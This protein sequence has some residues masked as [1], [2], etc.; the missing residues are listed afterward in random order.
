MSA[1]QPVLLTTPRVERLTAAAHAAM[2]APDG[3]RITR[4]VVSPEEYLAKEELRIAAYRD[5]VG[6]PMIL[7]RARALARIC[8]EWDTPIADGE[9][10]VG[11]QK[12]NLW[13]GGDE[14]TDPTLAAR[15][16]RVHAAY[17]ELGIMFGEGHMVCDYPRVLATGLRGQVERIDT[18][19]RSAA[20]DDER[21]VVWQAMKITCE[22]VRDFAGRYAQAARRAADT[23]DPARR[24]ELSEI[25]A[26][27]ERVPWEPAQSLREALQ[28]LWFVHLALHLESPAVAVSPGRLDQTLWPYYEAD[29]AS[30]RLT[31][32]EAIEALACLW[33]KFWE[34]DE[35]QNAVVGG[36][37]VDGHDA[38]NELT[39]LLLELTRELRAFQPSLSVRIHAD[40]PP[41]VLDAAAALAA[42]GT[43]QP[44]LFSDE[45]V[46][47]A[48]QSIGVPIAQARD[49]AVVGCYEAV[50]AGAEWGR[51]VAGGVQLPPCVLRALQRRPGS[52][53]EL[54]EGTCAEIVTDIERA[55]AA[56]NEHERAEATGAP[57]PFQSVLMRDCIEQ[58]QDIY[59]G[60]ARHNYTACWM[61]GL[62]TAVDS[63]VAAKRLVYEEACFSLDELQEL[64]R[65]DFAGREEARRCLI[66]RAPKFGN[67]LAEV[68]R[69]AREL[70]EFFCAEVVT[71][72]NPRGGRFQ[73]GLAMYQQHY[74]GLSTDATPDGRHRGAPFSAGIAPT[75]GC[76]TR[77]VTATLASCAK[78]PHT[79]GPNGNFLIISLSPATVCPPPGGPDAARTLPYLSELVR[80]YFAQGGSHVMFN[81]MDAATLRE[82]RVHPERHRDVMVRISGLSA[83]FVT[84]PPH[85]QDDIIAR[86]AR[87]L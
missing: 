51:T 87:G 21:T 45:A 28:S 62:A 63:L 31:R 49:W 46:I 24:T 66:Q 5:T 40:S 3:R 22:A 72:T 25:A 7:R 44:S 36:V 17:G 34:G 18:L 81:V 54:W 73:P 60:G 75:Q 33:L 2:T 71:H 58:G 80:T 74:A 42:A 14:Q 27:C 50:V 48:L 61:A 84:L 13:R 67:D 52:F 15:Y 29:L 16:R 26:I 10:I 11:S 30:G 79:L 38:T 9:W 39:L 55:V 70:C 68:D 20:P 8:R 76:N 23:A 41:E 4:F 6:Q 82:A 43:G 1:R 83:Y 65:S 86:T 19:V 85:I 77:G 57:S 78:L 64:L 47:P 53:R 69:L 56:A 37:G 32:E 12:G 59:S 35:S